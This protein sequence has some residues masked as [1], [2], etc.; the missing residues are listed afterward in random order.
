MID[1]DCLH[2]AYDR[3]AVLTDITAYISSG[4]CVALLGANG[5]GKS[6]L[7]MLLTGLYVPSQG[8]IKVHDMVSPGQERILRRFVG[9]LLQDADLQILGATVQED[10][11]LSAK[12]EQ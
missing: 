3:Q 11:E 7:L 2:F 9:L 5:S 6:T 10:L 12:A 1:I 4:E 8:L